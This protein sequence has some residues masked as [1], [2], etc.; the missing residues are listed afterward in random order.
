[1]DSLDSLFDMLRKERRRHVL[2]YLDAQDRPVPVEE[3]VAQVARWDAETDTPPVPEESYKRAEIVLTH[4]DLPKL[5]DEPYI[6]Y[7]REPGHI[8]LTQPPP[9][10]KAI[11]SLAE[12]I[13]N[14]QIRPTEFDEE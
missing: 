14:P 12:V 3:L 9:S 5:S 10:F 7:H 13:D 8:E 1:M 11:V 4:T 6:Q 2:Y